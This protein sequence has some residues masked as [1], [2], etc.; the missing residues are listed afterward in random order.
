MPPRGGLGSAA[1]RPGRAGGPRQRGV[2]RRGQGSRARSIVRAAELV[3]GGA[4]SPPP[5]ASAMGGTPLAASPEVATGVPGVAP[6]GA[7]MGARAGATT[8]MVDNRFLIR[9]PMVPSWAA[10]G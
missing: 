7:A 9:P 1:G 2:G 3:C 4:D 6:A 10:V 5:A 8:G